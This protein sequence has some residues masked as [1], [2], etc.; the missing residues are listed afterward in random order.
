[1]DCHALT[2]SSL[3]MTIMYNLD[4]INYLVCRVFKSLESVMKYFATLLDLKS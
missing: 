4:S 3:T 1:M 2:L